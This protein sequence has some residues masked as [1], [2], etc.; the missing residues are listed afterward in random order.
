[1]GL[2]QE[3][4]WQQYLWYFTFSMQNNTSD[5]KVDLGIYVHNSMVDKA[6][7][8]AVSL[9]SL[10]GPALQ[11]LDQF[12]GK[13]WPHRRTPLLRTCRTLRDTVLAGSKSIRLTLRNDTPADMAAHRQL[14]GRACAA[15][16]P[17]L[18]LSLIATQPS[19]STSRQLAL[20]SLLEPLKDEGLPN[21]HVLMLHVS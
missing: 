17:G 4:P 10:P 3:Q 11:L 18:R 16:P 13:A 21:V 20:H 8:A 12:V 7:C 5:L 14:L 9:D 15:V 2:K 19:T 6:C 1:M